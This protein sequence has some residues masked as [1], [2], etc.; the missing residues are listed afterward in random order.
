MLLRRG[1]WRGAPLGECC[2]RAVARRSRT[3]SLWGC[4]SMGRGGRLALAE[5]FA[6]GMYVD[7]RRWDGALARGARLLGALGAEYGCWDGALARGARLLGAL[8]AEYGCW[9]GALARG[10]RLLGAWGRNTDVGCA[11]ARGALAWGVG[12][13]IRMLGRCARARGALAWGVG[14]GIRMLG[15]CARAR[16]ARLLGAF[17]GGI[18]ALGRCARARGAL[19]WGAFGGALSLALTLVCYSWSGAGELRRGALGG[20]A[21]AAGGAA[22]R[23]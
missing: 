17:G 4:T 19:A 21:M 14:G 3:L 15:R 11:R 7:G 23:R 18:R 2:A 9:D 10:A 22:S 1:W 6:L 8:G 13:G 20:C 12:G 5:A 16:G